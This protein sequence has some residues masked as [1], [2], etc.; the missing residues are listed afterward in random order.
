MPPQE[1]VGHWF[2]HV[3]K[4]IELLLENDNGLLYGVSFGKLSCVKKN[5]FLKTEMIFDILFKKK[6]IKDILKHLMK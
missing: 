2:V 1:H 4:V 5:V 3:R 6:I